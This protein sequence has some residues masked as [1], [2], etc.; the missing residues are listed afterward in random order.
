M[1]SLIRTR[2][3]LSPFIASYCSFI[4][5]KDHEGGQGQYQPLVSV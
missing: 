5:Q 3:Y 2:L 1:G 4:A